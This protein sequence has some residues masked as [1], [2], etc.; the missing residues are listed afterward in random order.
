MTCMA[1][2]PSS[3]KHLPFIYKE[4]W[5]TFLP[6]KTSKNTEKTAPN[7]LQET[8]QWQQKH[9]P[10]LLGKTDLRKPS[11]CG[12]QHSD[13]PALASESAWQLIVIGRGWTVTYRTETRGETR[14]SHSVRRG[15]GS[16]QSLWCFWQQQGTLLPTEH[17]VSCSRLSALKL[18]VPPSLVQVWWS[19]ASWSPCG[20]LRAG[21]Q[22]FFTPTRILH[23]RDS[24]FS[25]LAGTVLALKKR[26]M[27]IH[28]SQR[29]AHL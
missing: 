17:F 24:P 22:I 8:Q 7:H 23:P 18:G 27:K 26:G 21:K 15:S 11:G 29:A 2:L 4:K 5:L 3:L 10:Q 19:R 6:R 14:C 13:K 9:S 1:S 12:E 16:M 28:P 25:S 20:W